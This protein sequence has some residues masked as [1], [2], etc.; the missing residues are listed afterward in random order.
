MTQAEIEAELRT[1]SDHVLQLQQQRSDRKKYEFGIGVACLI[2]AFAF[3]ASYGA[4]IFFATMPAAGTMYF[5][6]SAPLIFFGISLIG[7]SYR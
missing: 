2:L 6:T 3:L 4:N 5:L 7:N 1:L